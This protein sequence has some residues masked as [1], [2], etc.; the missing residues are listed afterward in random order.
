[1]YQNYNEKTDNSNNKK[2]SNFSVNQ[3]L[4]EECILKKN[5]MFKKIDTE[6]CTFQEALDMHS[7]NL[8][9][10]KFNYFLKTVE[11]IT[12]QTKNIDE[13]VEESLN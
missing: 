5:H 8:S 6:F 9:D 1:M 11:F 13:L 7:K 4:N 2:N 12:N 3:E 10:V